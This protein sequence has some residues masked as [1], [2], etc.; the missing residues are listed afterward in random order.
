MS[1]HL[2]NDKGVVDLV[3]PNIHDRYFR[4]RRSLLFTLD[5]FVLRRAHADVKQPGGIHTHTHT[6]DARQVQAARKK[7]GEQRYA[8][9]G[10]AGGCN[11][12]VRADEET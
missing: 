4:V 2:R 11:N 10:R 6:C 12:R 9:G 7:G 5:K 8:G 1:T 3:L